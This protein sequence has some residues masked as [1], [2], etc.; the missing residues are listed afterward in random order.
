MPADHNLILSTDSY[1]ASHYLQYPQN[2]ERISCYIE[3]RGGEFPRTLFFG[4]QMFLKAYLTKP[5]TQE[6]IEE[7]EVFLH[8][9]GLVFNRAG[10]EYILKK[11]GG[12]LPLAIEAVPEGTLVPLHNVLLQIV[13]TDPKCFWLTTYIETALL[14]SVWYPTTVATL[15]WQC[16]ALI[17]RYLEE[18][19]STLAGLPFQLHD[20]GARGV[21]SQESAEIGGAAHLVNFQGTDT[22]AGILAARRYYHEH[23][24]AFSI[25]AAEHSTVVTWGKEHEGDAY[26][27]MLKHFAKK[28]K[29]VSV[30]SD[31]YDIWNALKEIWGVRLKQDVIDNPGVLVIRPDSGDPAIIV[32]K[33]IDILFDIFGSTVNEKGYRVLPKNLRII[34]GDGVNLH[35]IG[36][37][38]EAM[39][40]KKQSAENI[41]FGMG[42]ALLQKL[43][44]DTQEF[45]MKAN[46]IQRNGKWHDVYKSPL[47][48]MAKAS[49]PGRLA[50]VHDAEVGFRTIRF[51]ELRNQK[52]VL[53]P[54]FKNGE[55]LKEWSFKEIRERSE[56]FFE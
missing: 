27:N 17:R 1:K 51:E 31:S 34:Q 9:H 39:K 37:C 29:L 5:I 47:T 54:V 46:A 50:L 28:G 16:K 40:Q 18:T 26:A 45:A 42:G 32:T 48:N 21:S 55:V 19:A 20:F 14:R 23:M 11:H 8:E 33:T 56:E 22:L 10:W 43:D 41:A 30:V 6:N 25:P 7:A 38:L 44:R 3:S 12:Y 49:K 24:A 53:I 4:L 13:N 52:N 35:T 2:T 36:E 15:S